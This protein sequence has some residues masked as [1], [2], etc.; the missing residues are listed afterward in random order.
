MFI[1]HNLLACLGVQWKVACLSTPSAQ[2]MFELKWSLMKYFLSAIFS[3]EQLEAGL[4]V[5]I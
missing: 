3:M 5:G 1:V 2:S 4:G